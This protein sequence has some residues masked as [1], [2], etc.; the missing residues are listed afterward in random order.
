MR[1][2]PAIIALAALLASSGL[3]H[4]DAVEDF[5][6]NRE[7]KLLIGAPPGGGYDTFSRLYARHAGR[8]IPGNPR[9]VPQNMPGGG[10]LI[11]TNALYNQ[12][13]RDGSV[14]GSGN[15]SIGTAALFG[16]PNARYDARRLG[17][18]GS[19]N[20]EVGLVVA[21]LDS[22]VKRAADLMRHE[23]V[24]GGSGATDGNVFFAA[25]MNNIL[26]TKFKVVAG[27]AGTANIALA[28]ER[29]EVQGT[30]SWHYSSINVN[31]PGWLRGEVVNVILQLSL[32]RHTRLPGIPT[33]LELANTDEQRALVRMIF[34]QQDMGRPLYVP[35]D[36]PAERLQA[37]RAGFAQFVQD[38]E[39]LAEVEKLGLE[40]NRPMSGP[41]IA[42]LIDELY[43]MPPA[44]VEKA[45]AAT[46]TTAP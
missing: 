31:K 5:Y 3:A 16:Q 43:R 17:W 6:R 41:E 45:V 44:L 12:Q 26:G 36:V 4:A 13:P 42:A 14:I 24:S 25:A 18:I 11:M 32:Q 34:A 40:V 15:G 19:L 33:V 39:V 23:L 46:K 21:R 22:P 37:L 29:G 27:Y 7:V 1:T 9:F 8:F 10:G 28:I 30:A 2:S 35:P 38:R 20:A